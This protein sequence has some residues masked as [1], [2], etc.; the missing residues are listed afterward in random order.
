MRDP[1]DKADCG[2]A[3]GIR[4]NAEEMAYEK[5][6][7]DALIGARRRRGLLWISVKRI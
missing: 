6:D 7:T 3:A 4:S 1:R 2:G 5:V